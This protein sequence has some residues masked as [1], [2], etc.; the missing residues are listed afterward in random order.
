VKRLLSLRFPR[1]GAS[2]E[3]DVETERCVENFSL[4]VFGPS[5][6]ADGLFVS[7]LSFPSTGGAMAKA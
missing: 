1:S 4:G 5:V 7:S 6:L 3:V 2:K